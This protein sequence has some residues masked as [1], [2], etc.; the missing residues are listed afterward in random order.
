MNPIILIVVLIAATLIGYK[1]ISNVPSL[2]HTPLMSGMNAL[3][4]VTVIGAIAATG[5][6]FL[7]D[8]GGNF[9]LGQIF[10]GM[11]IILAT[12][13]VVGGFGVTNRMLRMFSKKKKGGEQ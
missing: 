1:L 10:G 12:I 7:F 3:S 5:L 9:L 4:G 6:S 11:A 2:L 13:N 8:N